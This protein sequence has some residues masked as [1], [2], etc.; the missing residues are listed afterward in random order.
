MGRLILYVA[1]SLDGYI[2]RADGGLDWLDEIPNPGREDH[3]YHDLLA[4]TGSILVG[5]TT[6]E[7]ILG[8]GIDWP[9]PDHRTYVVSRAPDYPVSTPHTRV[10]S[11]N[12]IDAVHALKR[13]EN[14]DIWLMGGGILVSSL[15][16]M[17]A[18]DY[19]IISIVPTILGKG[20]PLFPEGTRESRWR[21]VGIHHYPTGIV[22]IKYESAGSG[23]TVGIDS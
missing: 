16:G 23:A 6:Y 9:Y 21:T 4:S 22:G 12:L 7:K 15:L 14:K 20:I 8:F 18:I 17:G 3:G 19:M 5:R 10:L 1:T 11:S 2:A 13:E